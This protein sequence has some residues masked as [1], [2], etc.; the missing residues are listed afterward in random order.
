LTGEKTQAAQSAEAAATGVVVI[1]AL[2][3]ER[4]IRAV[5]TAAL[6][7]CAKVILV[8]DGSSDRTSE[9]VADLPLERI[10]HAAPQGIED[11]IPRDHALERLEDR[12]VI[13]D[14]RVAADSI[15]FLGH[16]GRVIDRQ[17]YFRDGLRGIADEQA[18]VVP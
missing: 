14:H 3:E 10:R 17:Q 18:D 15:A 8:D 1:P 2:N 4:A 11:G 9:V 6:R 16:F 13:C 12:R 5:L 7:Y